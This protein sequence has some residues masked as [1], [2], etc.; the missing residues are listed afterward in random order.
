MFNND[1]SGDL[2]VCRTKRPG[3]N[4]IPALVSIQAED[5]FLHP[6]GGES[7]HYRPHRLR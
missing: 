5:R 6:P 2:I 7:G 1:K 3:I 4:P